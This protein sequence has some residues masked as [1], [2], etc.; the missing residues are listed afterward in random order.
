L[1]AFDDFIPLRFLATLPNDFS[2]PDYPLL[3][4]FLFSDCSPQLIAA[5]NA[6]FGGALLVLVHRALRLEFDPLFAALGTLALAGAALTPWPGFADGPLI[7]FA[8]GAALLFR[9]E[10]GSSAATLLALAAFTKNE[11]AAFT[12][13]IAIAL[14]L[15]N[16]KLLR[17]TMPAALVIAGW[18][19]IK[20]S[21]GMHTDLFASGIAT[22]V[23][24]NSP[25]F[26][27]A[28]ATVPMYQP[29][30]W[31]AAIIAIAIGRREKFL[32]TIAAIQLVFYFGA[33]LITPLDL[34]GHVNGSWERISSH[35]TM[36][37]AFAG[38]TAIGER[39]QR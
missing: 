4:P 12:V 17:Y 26:F 32:L 8:C 36:L 25:H 15:C 10:R 34:A 18:T 16:R 20:L 11:G 5:L 39:L 2:H 21:F 33:Y 13:A 35:V 38:V 9:M 27:Q 29:L 3:I 19:A 28:F 31:I 14:I 6:A 24:H 30:L 7:A 37:V 1:I 23:V 22:R